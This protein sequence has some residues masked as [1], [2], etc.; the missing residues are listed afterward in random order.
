[1]FGSVLNS[2]FTVY[3]SVL[4]QKKEKKKKEVCLVIQELYHSRNQ[5]EY[6]EIYEDDW[7]LF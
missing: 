4:L 3:E 6:I 5:M 1:M 7:P 2:R